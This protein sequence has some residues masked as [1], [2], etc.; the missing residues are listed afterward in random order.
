MPSEAIVHQPTTASGPLRVHPEN[1]R[2][3][4]NAEGRAVYLVGSHTWANFQD[5][6]FEG[7]KPFDYDAYMDF[8]VE[9]RFNFM[10]FWTWEHAAWAAWSPEK[11]IFSPT[12][13]ARTGP[14]L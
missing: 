11:V 3:F 13:Y 9:H 5:I 12:P 6:G 4:A 10:R 1:T 8:M 2:Y 14:G 7:D